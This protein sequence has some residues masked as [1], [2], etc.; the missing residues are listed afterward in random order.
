M[1]S[2]LPD[3]PSAGP[4]GF[5]PAGWGDG[6][7][8]VLIVDDEPDARSSLA[9]LFEADG[10]RTVEAATGPDALR[11]AQ[12]GPD[13]VVL[14]VFLPGLDGREVC[15]RLKADPATAAIPVVMLSGRAVTASDRVGGLAGGAD[16]YLTKPADPTLLIAQCRALL[17][18][19]QA[20]DMNRRA[21]AVLEATGDAFLALDRDWRCTYL[22]PRAEQLFG[23]GAREL[24]GRA[25][26]EVAPEALGTESERACRR[27]V[28]DRTPV[29]VEGPFGPGGQWV[30][31]R[32]VP[33]AHGLGLVVRDATRRKRLE[34]RLRQAQKMEAVGRLAGGVAHD[35]NNLLTVI[36]GYGEAVAE[37]LP[38][39]H[40]A[41]EFVA[42]IRGAGERAAG[43]TGQ[44]LAFG[45]QSVVAPRAVDLNAV[46]RGLR[47]MLGRLLGEDI[48]LSA[49]PA[50]D[51]GAVHADPGL[52]EQ[53]VLNL[54]VNARDAMP[55]GG[56]LTVETANVELGEEY[57]RAN[58]DVRPGAYGLLAVS[59][60]GPGI[61]A[62]VLPHIFE[63]FFT[64]KPLGRGTGLGLATVHGIVRQF[65]GHLAVY[66]EVGVGTSFKVYL[67]RAGEGVPAAPSGAPRAAPL[68]GTETVL[69]VEDEGAVR[70][71]A[72]HV[73]REAGY[74]VL[75]AGGADEALTAAGRHT[76]AVHLLLT[77]VVMPGRSGR[78]VAERLRAD[79]PGLRVVYMSGYTDDAVV[80]HGVLAADVRFLQKPFTAASLARKV[81]DAL[82]APGGPTD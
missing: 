79:R 15:R 5:A 73:L 78:E 11:L 51:L 59:D 80:R 39:D 27:A 21:V 22:N 53:V 14:D 68:G 54:C 47:P 2:R 55:R 44:L 66:T 29:E 57:A 41:Q 31:V 6:P 4:P 64:T 42:A 28:A 3:A 7:I 36:N 60:T 77:D 52:V 58:P 62:D 26:W 9:W 32:A 67:P 38:A 23:R 24:V 61:P 69:L 34:E 12:N 10:F 40:P 49:H 37:F 81:R 70:Q 72:A 35:F 65:D 20:E 71:L 16:V 56:R 43:L 17:R 18:L 30:E 74:T 50:P 1:A 45:R 76:G 46:V 63:P 19:R 25:L 82:D 48:D 33:L 8:T 13:V 75:E